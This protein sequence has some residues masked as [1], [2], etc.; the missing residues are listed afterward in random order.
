MDTLKKPNQHTKPKS[1][2]CN[3]TSATIVIR[4]WLV[5]RRVLPTERN[6][7]PRLV[8]YGSFGKAEPT[9]KTICSVWT[10]GVPNF[11]NTTKNMAGAKMGCVSF[12]YHLLIICLLFA[13]CLL[14]IYYPCGCP[15][16]PTPIASGLASAGSVAKIE[17]MLC[18]SRTCASPGNC[19]KCQ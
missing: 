14:M 3:S 7:N 1:E 4:V 17:H 13:Y 18:A 15:Q 11:Q 10:C 2:I 6:K 5:D 19:I 16:L 9:S 8:T 12:A